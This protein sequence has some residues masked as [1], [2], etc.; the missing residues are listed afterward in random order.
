MYLYKYSPKIHVHVR[1]ICMNSNTYGLF[2]CLFKKKGTNA[3]W[4][5]MNIF[6]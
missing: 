4:M 3:P 2:T 1:T 6:Q 5:R